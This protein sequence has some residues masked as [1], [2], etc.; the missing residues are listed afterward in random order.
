M[1]RFYLPAFYSQHGSV[2]FMLAN[3]ILL[4]W[5]LTFKV[6]RENGNVSGN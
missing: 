2:V 1:S 5:L 3:L 4:R 6:R